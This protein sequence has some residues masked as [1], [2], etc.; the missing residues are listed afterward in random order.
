MYDIEILEQQ[1]IDA[2][3]NLQWDQAVEFNKQILKDDKEN[4]DACLRLG[5]AFMRQKNYEEAKKYYHKSLKLRP[6]NQVAI[7]NLERMTL[8]ESGNSHKKDKNKNSSLNPSLFLEVPGKTKSVSVVNLGQKKHLAAVSIGQEVELKQK[9]RRIEV[10]SLNNEYIGSLPD[11]LSK[12]LIFFMKAK[13]EYTAY[14]QESSLTKIVI[15][16]KEE[17]KGKKVMHYTSFPANIQNNLD[18]MENPDDAPEMP[19]TEEPTEEEEEETDELE[20]LADKI[21]DRD[22]DTAMLSEIGVAENDEDAQEEEE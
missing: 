5:F 8:M 6:K 12:R 20:T 19:E 22:E 3:I 1:A 4:V 18:Q 14:V 11:D 15:F 13:S 9:K 7:E 21:T 16:I 2:A 10:R 17:T